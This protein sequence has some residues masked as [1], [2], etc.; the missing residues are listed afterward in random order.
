MRGV[1]RAV[2]A[3]VDRAGERA[4][5][6]CSRRTI[7]A[8]GGCAVGAFDR[9]AN[10]AFGWRSVGACRRCAVGTCCEAVMIGRACVELAFGRGR[11]GLVGRRGVGRAGSVADCDEGVV[12]EQ[13]GSERG[14]RFVE[15]LPFLDVSSRSV[16]LL[17]R[18]CD[19]RPGGPAGHPP[20]C[21]AVPGAA[22]AAAASC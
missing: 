16:S 12:G 14:G 18:S 21:G 11:G 9:C 2:G 13:V 22:P 6:A 5:G 1:G 17:D 10:G 3:C 19:V 4:V 8:F 7:G 20:E 15:R